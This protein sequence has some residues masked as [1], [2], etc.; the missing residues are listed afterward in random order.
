MPPV[1]AVRETPPPP[2][3]N[4]LFTALSR[5][6]GR[7][8]RIVRRGFW[9][10]L[11][12]F[13]ARLPFADDLLAAYFCARD[14]ATGPAAKAVLVAALAYFVLPFD[15]IPD[16]FAVAGFSDDAAVLMAALGT[17]SGE[18]RPRHRRAAR[19]ALRRLRQDSL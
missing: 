17:L 8:W 12:R 10:K 1:P 6:P 5:Q 15:L 2:A 18:M 4:R 19:R 14:P 7:A 16:L 3:D 9:P 13:A 11:Q